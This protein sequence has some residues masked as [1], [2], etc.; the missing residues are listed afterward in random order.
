MALG[1][2]ILEIL[3][4][5]SGISRIEQSHVDQIALR[6]TQLQGEPN[7]DPEGLAT[8]SS[9]AEIRVE[10]STRRAS[11]VRKPH[12]MVPWCSLEC[13]P[14]C[15]AGGRGF[16]SRRDRTTEHGRVAQ[17]AERPPEKR[18]VTGSTPVP[19]TT[20]PPTAR[21][22]AQPRSGPYPSMEV[23]PPLLGS[24]PPW[25]CDPYWRAAETAAKRERA[26]RRG[27]WRRERP[28]G[29]VFLPCGPPEDHASSGAAGSA[30]VVPGRGVLL[31]HAG[32]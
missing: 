21:S 16:K 31:G 30:D 3:L 7:F 26:G 32:N 19:T 6:I 24:R 25:D 15:Q 20:H 29:R 9:Q 5:N 28:A 23:R 17:L 14:A 11:R 4:C 12:S 18:K 8:R 22:E 27:G 10:Q 2:F 1:Q 13:T